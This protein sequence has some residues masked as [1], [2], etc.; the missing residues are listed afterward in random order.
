MNFKKYFS[1]ALAVFLLGLLGLYAGINHSSG[2]KP[3]VLQQ[4][5]SMHHDNGAK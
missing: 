2:T 4:D 3:P 1:A 5:H